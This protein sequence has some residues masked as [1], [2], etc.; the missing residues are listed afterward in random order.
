MIGYCRAALGR[1]RDARRSFRASLETRLSPFSLA[2]AIAMSVPGVASAISTV[3]PRV[4]RPP[5]AR[6]GLS[7]ADPLR[8]DGRRLRRPSPRAE[9]RGGQLQERSRGDGTRARPL[10]LHGRE[11][12]ARQARDEPPAVAPAGEAEADLSFFVLFEDE[13]DPETIKGV[14][15]GRAA[16]PS[17]G[18]PTTTGASTASPGISLRPST[19]RSRPTATRFPATTRSATSAR[20]S[21]SGPATATPTT[22]PAGSWST[23]SPSSASPMASGRPPSSGCAPR[24]STSAAGASAGP[25]AESSTTRWSA[26]SARAAST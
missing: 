24:A 12:G 7:H 20:S 15:A 21:R 25:R 23:T 1:S 14:G 6:L 13:I 4:R 18:S 22:G 26:C 16:Q 2:A 19:G 17:T 5:R 9:L 3:A 8:G 10:R 11:A